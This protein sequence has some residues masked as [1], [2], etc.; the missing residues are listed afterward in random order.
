MH[1]HIDFGYMA[2]YQYGHL[3]PAALAAAVLVICRFRG[4]PRIVTALAGALL[5]WSLSAAAIVQFGLNFNGRLGLPTQNFLVSGKGHVLDMGAGTGRSTLMVLEAR[6]QTTVVALDSFAESYQQHF[7]AAGQGGEVFQRGQAR[8]MANLAAAGVEKRATVKQADMRELPYEAATFDGVVSTYAIDHLGRTGSGKAL[9][10]A[11]RVLK[12]GGEF[13]L[14]VVT[15]DFYL[16]YVL[17]PMMLHSRMPSAASWTQALQTVGFQV[18]E[19]GTVPGSF[20]FLCR[21]GGV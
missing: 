20:W 14:M 11:F 18:A 10:E 17:G 13:L 1:S 3:I 16:Q 12:P 8:L 4:W 6:P 9:Q 2:I 5:F 15:K 19:Q 7:A 21:K